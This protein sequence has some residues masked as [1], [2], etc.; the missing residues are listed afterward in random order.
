MTCGKPVAH[1]YEKYKKE[2]AAGKSPKN[3]LDKLGVERFCCRNVFL[4]HKDL[5][6][7]IGQFK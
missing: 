6:P 4:S 1:L 3:V 7:R 2:I 5:V